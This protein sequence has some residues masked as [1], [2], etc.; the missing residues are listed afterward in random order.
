MTGKWLFLLAKD[1]QNSL[2]VLLTARNI[3]KEHVLEWFRVL[4][5]RSKPSSRQYFSWVCYHSQSFTPRSKSDNIFFKQLKILTENVYL[6]KRLRK[7]FKIKFWPENPM[8]L[9]L[10]WYHLKRF[11]KLHKLSHPE[12][13]SVQWGRKSSNSRNSPIWLGLNHIGTTSTFFLPSPVKIP[14]PR[15]LCLTQALTWKLQ[16]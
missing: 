6:R 3:N 5:N 12:L 13:W 2:P 11:F 10:V 1:V 4:F 8:E 9:Q 16:I 15:N 7:N 14:V